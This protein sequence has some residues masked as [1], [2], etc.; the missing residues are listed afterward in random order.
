MKA[1]PESATPTAEK[2]T[3]SSTDE[4]IGNQIFLFSCGFFFVLYLLSGL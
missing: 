3:E 1:L 4:D 2:I